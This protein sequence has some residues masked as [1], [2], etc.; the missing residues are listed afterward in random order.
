MSMN[1]CLKA[2]ITAMTSILVFSPN[3]LRAQALEE[4]I[5]T[6]QRREQ[7]MQE[8]PISLEAFG[9]KEMARQ[10]YRDLNA[11]AAF[12][13]TVNVDQESIIGPAIAIR[14]FGSTG[15]L[16][17]IESAT[18]IFVDGV[19]F[20]R[21]SMMKTAFMDVQS[22]EVLKGPQPVYFG[23]NA[24]AGAFNITSKKPGDTWE[25]DLDIEYGNNS[26]TDVSG[27]IGGPINDTWRM[28][29]AGK[30]E[31]TAG[32]LRDILS[33]ESLGAFKDMGGR[34]TLQWL[35]SE[36]LTFTG[37]VDVARLR[38]D[39]EANA[40]CYTKGDDLIFGRSGP[41]VAGANG[42]TGTI[43]DER[44]IYAA[45]PAG[46]GWNTPL[47]LPINHD[48]Y[49]S[50]NGVSAGGPYYPLPDYVRENNSI[51]GSLDVRE[52]A[53]GFVLSQDSDNKGIQGYEDLDNVT[54]TLAFEYAADNGI[55][56]AGNVAYVNYLR[57]YVRDNRYAYSFINFQGR[58]EDYDQWSGEI[59]VS[60]ATGGMFEWYVGTFYQQGD[61]DVFSSSLRANLITPQRF[62]NVWEDQEWKSL[63]GD[64]KFNFMDNK[65]TIEL[66]GRAANLDKTTYVRGYAA[67]WVYNSRPCDPDSVNQNASP[68]AAIIAACTGT[69]DRAVQ[70]NAS[71]V[72]FFTDD[73]VDLSNL[74]T[75]LYISTQRAAGDNGPTREV[76]GVSSYTS[77]DSREIP[78]NWLPSQAHA[79]GLTQPN[80]DAREGPFKENISGTEYDPQVVLSYR[81]SEDL[82]LYGKY[83]EAF[84]AGGF[85][86][87]QTSIPNTLAAYTFGPEMASTYELGAKGTYLDGRGRFDA[88]LF[89]LSFKGLQLS[90]ATP[91]PDDPFANL[92][93]GGQRVRGLE[94]SN[95]FAVTDQ[96]T[97]GLGGA[98]L[99]GEMTDFTNVPCTQEEVVEI[100]TSG[101]VNRAAPTATADYRIDRSGATAPRTPKWK[102]VADLDYWMPVFDTY[103]ATFNAKGFYSD[104][105]ISDYNGFT[106]TNSWDKH[107]D[108]NL[109]IGFGD[110]D[111]VW[112]VSL[113]GRNLFEAHQKY[114]PKYDIYPTGLLITGVSPNSYASYGIKLQYNYQ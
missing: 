43:G 96:L 16:V 68:T 111:D 86:T 51:Y 12:S 98:F 52:A 106:L 47:T 69:H 24:T 80:F 78:P 15:N 1:N 18:P 7:S 56:V 5:V 57:N 11:L 74:W 34:L 91:N 38:K 114:H 90:I 104:G 65:A 70:L 53:E 46:E 35:P 61:L 31:D 33:G 40:I 21:M 28:R 25:G 105:Y 73:P 55:N 97:F 37:K 82:T 94:F 76:P 39:A 42:N 83:A 49:S 93:A 79:I 23:Q 84:K 2:F 81:P 6:A 112:S 100:A 71:Q 9:A 4:I 113:Y 87:G 110:M 101:C 36:Q 62:N 45:P 89:T 27:G 66:G 85:D 92:N 88:T 77:G 29:V 59:R 14:G 58:E 19:H 26:T 72:R 30:Y 50:T 108:L 41:G 102:F 103:K 10:G 13:P 20:A 22:V 8:V 48:C 99:D 95:N 107:G 64:I 44:S 32:Y 60:S 63:F 54:S 17:T 75:T 3:V 67:T 109:I